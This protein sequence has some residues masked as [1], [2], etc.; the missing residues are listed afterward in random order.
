[1]S[2]HTYSQKLHRRAQNGHERRDF[3]KVVIEM[4]ESTDKWVL[5]F[6][7]EALYWLEHLAVFGALVLPV[8]VLVLTRGERKKRVSNSLNAFAAMAILLICTEVA[9]IL[10]SEKAAQ[11]GTSRS[12]GKAQIKYE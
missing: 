7:G 2:I 6:A 4:Y 5:N 1:V 3:W 10:L 11:I 9:K 12:A 8:V